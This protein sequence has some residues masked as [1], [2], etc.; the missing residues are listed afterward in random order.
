MRFLWLRNARLF[1]ACHF[2]CFLI[3]FFRRR[4]ISAAR[5][6]LL[7]F[8]HRACAARLCWGFISDWQTGHFMGIGSLERY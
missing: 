7:N 6:F 2:A 3:P 1:V 8:A 5:S 4:D